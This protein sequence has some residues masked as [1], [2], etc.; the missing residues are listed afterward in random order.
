MPLHPLPALALSA[1]ALA[2]CAAQPPAPAPMP[3]PLRIQVKLARPATDADAI[4]RRAS[5][6]AQVPV[7]YVAAT[8]EQWHALAIDCASDADCRQ[9]LARLQ[10]A[11]AIYDQVS[12]DT[13]RGVN[14]P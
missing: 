5:E 10:A 8:S 11:T 9:A 4:A 13:R 14:N 3:T 12:A 2:A 6:I 7:R 1:L